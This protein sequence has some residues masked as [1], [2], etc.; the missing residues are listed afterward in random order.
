MQNFHWN[1][2]LSGDPS[3]AE[4]RVQ[5]YIDRGLNPLTVS[6]HG[7]TLLHAAVRISSL[8][9]AQLAISLGVPINALAWPT[10]FKVTSGWTALFYAIRNGNYEMC[11]FLLEH[12]ASEVKSRQRESPLDRAVKMQTEDIFWLLVEFGFKSISHHSS[13]PPVDRPLS[14]PPTVVSHRFVWSGS[15]P[16][17]INSLE[18][19]ILRHFEDNISQPVGPARCS[20]CNSGLA[21]VDE[22]VRRKYEER[23]RN[24]MVWAATADYSSYGF[25]RRCLICRESVVSLSEQFH[26]GPKERGVICSEMSYS[27]TKRRNREAYWLVRCLKSHSACAK[28]VESPF[29]PRRVID[30]D[31]IGSE[32]LTRLLETTEGQ[33]GTYC[34]LSYRWSSKPVKLTLKNIDDLK[35][36]LPLETLPIQIQHAIQV[37]RLLGFRYL[38]VDAL[39]IIQD[40]EADWKSEAAKM[41]TIYSNS[42]LTIAAVDAP[43]NIDPNSSNLFTARDSSVST[44]GYRPRGELDSRG[45]VTQEE[46]LSRRVLSFTKAGLFWSCARWVCSDQCPDGLVLPKFSD[47]P[48]SQRVANDEPNMNWQVQVWARGAGGKVH[49]Y[50]LWHAVM[51]DYTRRCLT[52]ES[53]RF[54]ALQGVESLFTSRLED[55]NLGGVWRGNTIKDLAWY[56]DG[57]A[58]RRQELDAPSWSWGSATGPI[59]FLSDGDMDIGLGLAPVE[60]VDVQTSDS[61]NGIQGSITLVGGPLIP[62]IFHDSW[63]SFILPPTR[64]HPE[65]YE[66]RIPLDEAFINFMRTRSEWRPDT[67]RYETGRGLV[68]YMGGYGLGLIRVGNSEN[69]FRRIGL[70]PCDANM[71]RVLKTSFRDSSLAQTRIKY[72]LI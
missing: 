63:L 66:P 48:R 34:T 16:E 23:E 62:V 59:S 17:L 31:R 41:G 14:G 8:P 19:F 26:P 6:S 72:T 68:L 7:K 36:A 3:E 12:G 5:D 10:H 43:G 60:V 65:E 38:W 37:A 69:T 44:P 18:V 70:C 2:L 21:S 55:Q 58:M 61:G 13:D 15:P 22:S 11:R 49:G 29:L 9:L 47:K 53:D 33:R 4:A 1:S 52:R 57:P 28:D 24:A 45:W 56:R 40:S 20:L 35:T 64:R 27:V 25:L 54:I 67:E 51:Q 32:H 42:N 39:C 30:V 71:V 50:R 46:I